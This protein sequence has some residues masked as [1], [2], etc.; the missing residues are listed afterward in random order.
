M[1]SD[2]S[3]AWFTNW[4]VSEEVTR[5]WC[6]NVRRE[7][8]KGKNE[9]GDFVIVLRIPIIPDGDG[10]LTMGAIEEAFALAQHVV[11]LHNKNRGCDNEST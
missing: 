3:S 10:D 6:V 8:H 11:E 1:M 2:Q 5:D 4:H 9:S 7:Y